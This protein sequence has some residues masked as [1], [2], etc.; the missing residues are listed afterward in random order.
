MS[1][2]SS[3]VLAGGGTAGHVNPLLSIASSIRRLEPKA[4]ISVIGTEVGLERQLVPAAGFDM[5]TIE[6]VPFPRSIN[7]AAFAFPA[8]W[9]REVNKV[10][11]ILTE[12]HADV[13]V[14]VGGY[15]SAPAYYAAH[16]L[17][18]P[19]V[20]HEQNARAGMA[21]KLGARW[22]Q[23]IG[24]VYENTGLKAP[25]GT[26]IERV[27]LPLR[28]A[29]ADVAR[30]M[31]RN[32]AQARRQ[33]AERLGLDPSRPILLVTG[34]SLGAQSLNVAVANAAGELLSRA[35]V[36]HLT[37]KGKMGQV[38]QLVTASA[39]ESVLSG[40][41]SDQRGKGDYHAAEYLE[42]ID[43]AFACADLVICRSGAGT[44]AEIAALGLPAV[45]VPLPIGNGE[46]RFN[47]EPVVE[48]GG[49]FLVPDDRFTDEWV[50][51]HVPQLL[52][53]GDR[54]AQV[55]RAAWGYGIRDAAQTMASR[56]LDIA[57][58]ARR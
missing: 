38:R 9:I 23:F 1:E 7:R 5:D 2:E 24:T 51:G 21:N 16:K 32:R 41:G 11:T 15:A 48:A 34:G 52:A 39:G 27:G 53:D 47:A 54:L 42:R 45:Y 8:R 10:K 58:K 56:V 30:S 40:I 20:I 36:I 50:T 29:I 35:Q 33:G 25:S 19:I 43:Q 55:A 28:P 44:V 12:R 18:I 4:S 3:I 22:A 46:Q 37:G 31:E 26:V 6:K 49:G 13:L 14:G 17:G 57:G